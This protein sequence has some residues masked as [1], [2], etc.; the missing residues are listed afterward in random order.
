MNTRKLLAAAACIMLASAASCS[1]NS[2]S[3]EKKADTENKNR[4]SIVFQAEGDVSKNDLD[5]ITEVIELR[6]PE[7]IPDI[8]Q[9]FSK[10][11]DAKTVTMTFDKENA[12]KENIEVFSERACEKRLLEFRK[13]DKA[14]D[15]LI[16]TNDDVEK[17]TNVVLSNSDGGFTDCISIQFNSH[18]TDVFASVTSEIAGTDTPISIWLDG[19]LI[20]SPAV[21]A[22]ITNGNCIISGNFDTASA[23]ELANKIDSVPLP[24]EVSVKEI[25]Y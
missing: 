20:S 12:P 17:A 18:G 15:E 9:K 14:D 11:Y 2:Q 7:E 3:K 4:G 6:T 25:N 19:E 5:A 23:S 10:D 22:A 1:D 16:L 8:G 21:S 13:G 24:Y